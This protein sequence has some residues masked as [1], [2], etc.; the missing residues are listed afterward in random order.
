MSV[1]ARDYG[2]S[3]LGDVIVHGTA[4]GRETFSESSAGRRIGFAQTSCFGVFGLAIGIYGNLKVWVKSGDEVAVS[5]RRSFTSVL[6]PHMRLLFHLLTTC[7]RT[8][9]V[10]SGGEVSCRFDGNE[11]IHPKIRIS[12]HKT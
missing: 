12:S 4:V 2:Y 3:M 10:V 5:A 6:S 9:G 11:P 8:G 7:I 1:L